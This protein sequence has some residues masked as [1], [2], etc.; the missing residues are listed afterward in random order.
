MKRN[1]LSFLSLLASG[2]LLISLTPLFASPKIDETNASVGNYSTDPATYYSSIT[3]HSG[4]PLMGQL[5]DLMVNSHQKYTTYTDCKTPET[6]YGMEP[7]STSS[8]ITDFYTQKDIGYS[9]GGGARGTWNREHVWCQSHSI[10][11]ATSK[12]LWGEKY[13]GSDLQHIRP[14]ESTLNSSRNNNRYGEFSNLGM[15]R[16]SYKTY[17]KDSNGKTLYDG[18]YVDAGN[19]I[20]EPLDSVKGDVARILMYTFVHY[21]SYQYIGGTTDGILE[22]GESCGR[23]DIT[24]IVHTFAGTADAAWETLLRW[25]ENDPVSEEEI[26]RNNKA[27]NYQGNRN[28][29]IDNPS[30]ASAIWGDVV[31]SINVARVSLS[32]EEMNLPV[33]SAVQLSAT[34]SPSN[35]SNKNITWSSSNTSVATVSSTGLVSGVSKGDATITVTTEDGSF[36]DTCL[37][38]VTEVENAYTGTAVLDFTAQGYVDKQDVSTLET[39]VVTA[40]LSKGSGS[41]APK[42]YSNGD[43]VRLYA[44][45][46][47]TIS[48]SFKISAISFVFGPPDG[49]NEISASTGEWEIPNWT[50]RDNIIV[51]TLGP[52]TGTHHKLK[53]ISVTYSTLKS[54]S[55]S[56]Q[57]IDYEVGDTF[58][59][60]GTLIASYSDSYKTRVTPTL[61]SPPDMSSEGEKI[62][63][64]EYSENGITART[65]YS[66][67]VTIPIISVDGITLNRTSLS[68]T[69]GDTFTLVATISPIN[70][71]NQNLTWE[72]DDEDVAYVD[73]EGL[74]TAIS[75]GSATISVTTEDG[76]Y[77]ATC[78]VTVT[79]GIV[80]STYK[81]ISSVEELM[82]G[83]KVVFAST[84]SGNTLVMKE[85]TGSDNNIKAIG[86]TLE[87]NTLTPSSGY[88]LYTVGKD[89]TGYTFK[90]SNNRYLYANGAGS[91]KN[92]LR[93]N[94]NFQTNSHWNITISNGAFS[95][96]NA[97]SNTTNNNLQCNKNNPLFSCYSTTQKPVTLYADITA[98][99][100]AF[101]SSYLHLD[102]YSSNSNWCKDNEHNFYSLAKN[103]L[104][105]LGNN[106]IEEFQN[107]AS[108]NAAQARYEAWAA[109]NNDANPYA[110]NM[111]SKTSTILKGGE[112]K[113]APILIVV[114]IVVGLASTLLIVRLRKKE[115]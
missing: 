76:G 92:Y 46:T 20:Y 63:T 75:A 9:W 51:F 24:E 14:I 21:S 10:D 65:S 93:A 104:L 78:V 102:D 111:G 98:G 33:G 88:G 25:N 114:T 97:D 82:L 59:Y 115:D 44:N 4:S 38:H 45:N 37:I 101:I 11:K 84:V 95:I 62:V 18:G 39:D 30:Y 41:N 61:V 103:K 96:V 86:G 91:G 50:G 22:P 106:Y 112:I 17:S 47:F 109:A 74:V 110:A 69:T 49:S 81:L 13:G 42:Y 53:K 100:S 40:S 8:Y 55:T 64:L 26:Y 29:F 54:I 87:G 27:A 105:A 16:D 52:N 90:D 32:S 5:H 58:E 28:P 66:I 1:K 79:S 60:D 80:N 83:A 68:L 94:N 36:T 35:A 56:G 77:S 85:H 72:S 34:I 99:T 31:E 23:L 70:A 108:F 48:S 12:Q 57:T 2:A 71:T 3:A 6:V 73:E 67:Y 7:G 15:S 107:N 43:A 19:D 89:T 113:M